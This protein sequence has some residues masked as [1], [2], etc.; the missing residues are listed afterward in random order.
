VF[1]VTTP[2]LEFA[3]IEEGRG[4]LALLLH[5][6]PDT[7]HTWDHLRPAL[8]RAGYRAVSPFMRGYAP[9]SIPSDG[10]Y[11]ADTL[12]SDVIALIDALSPGEPAIVVGHDWG[13]SA[14]YSAATL[15]PERIRLLVT[16]AIPHPAGVLPTP[17]VLWALR[18]FAVLRLA[19]APERVRKDDF[20]LV[21]E[22]VRRWSPGWD[23]PPDETA[24]VKRAFR[25]PGCVEAAVGYYRALG[26]TLPPA[27]RKKITVPTVSFAGLH[28]NIAPSQYHR[29]ARRF[30]GPYEVVEMPGGHFM[31]R[32]HPEHFERELLAAIARHI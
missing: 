27:Q 13:A 31:H 12:G 25:E 28:D 3:C 19:S 32:Q 30:T 7:A 4:P 16:L 6:F 8:A 1:R 21:D 24:A 18:H 11:D 20:A 22:L 29:A 26:V 10:A 14:A 9:T 2:A 15:G 5:G 23:P 17:S